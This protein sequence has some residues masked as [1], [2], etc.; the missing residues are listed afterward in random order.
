M[1][2]SGTTFAGYEVEGV[3]GAGGAG[4]LYRA[5]QLR[6]D[7]PVALKLV[8][9][10]VA[11]D[12]VV[13]ER[14]RRE[15]RMVA[16]LD[17]PNVVPLYEAGEEDGSVYIVTRWVE[18]TELGTLIEDQGPLSVERAARTTAQIAAALEVAHEQGLVHR[19]VKPSNVILTAEDH[20][21][22]TDFG[23]AK[24]AE[25]AP[26][27]TGADRM[28]GTVD[29][30]APEQIEGG[31]PDARS[32]VYS[33]GCVLYEVLAGEPPFASHKGGMAKMWAQVNAD[34]PPLHDRRPDVPPALE[35]VASEAMAKQPEQ[36][37]SAA[38]FRRSVLA[39]VGE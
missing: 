7:R 13:R 38:G 10:E 5:R 31:D 26:G 24:R 18:G 9:P 32:D 23:L 4:I 14:L 19:D 16:S 39:A 36:R 22:L 12:P 30:V 29:Y 37:P 25:T 28:L 34:A 21:Y 27:L 35:A 17:H 2:E 33:L 20:V 6:L 1:L 15:A 3:V 11:R 8:E